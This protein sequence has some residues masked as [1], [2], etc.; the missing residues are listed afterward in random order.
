LTAAQLFQIVNPLA[1]LGWIVLIASILLKKPVWRDQVAGR[2]WPLGFAVLYSALI[3]FFFFKAPGGFDTLANVQ[4]LFTSEWAALAGWVHYLAFDLFVG[5]YISRSVMTLGMSR[6]LLV[7]LL[8]LTFM[9]GPMGLLGF[10]VARLLFQG[11]SGA[12]DHE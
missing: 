11:K 10:E 6:L 7:P 4:L 2:F 3:I 12:I 8:P 5:T 9:F 1:L